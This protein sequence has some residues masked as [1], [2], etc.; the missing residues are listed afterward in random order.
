MSE[1]IEGCFVLAPVIGGPF[2]DDALCPNKVFWQCLQASRPDRP[3]VAA[4]LRRQGS[5]ASFRKTF[6]SPAL[7]LN[8][9]PYEIS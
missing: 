7:K 9:T 6:C 1:L 4:A 3:A 5:N 2:R 8:P